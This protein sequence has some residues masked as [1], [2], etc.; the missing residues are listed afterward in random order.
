MKTADCYI[1]RGTLELLTTLGEDDGVIGEFR[2][3]P[4]PDISGGKRAVV[5]AVQHYS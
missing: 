3:D 1:R 4:R 5:T 2:V